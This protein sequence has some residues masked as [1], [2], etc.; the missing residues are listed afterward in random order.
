MGAPIARRLLMAG[1]AVT[2]WN[3]TLSRAGVLTEAGARLA[4]S[5]AESIAGAEIVI[6]MLT[7]DAAVNAALF[8]PG[9]AAPLLR[10]GS[11]VI[12]MST[13]APREVRALA[14]RLPEGIDLVDAPVAGSTGAA[15]AGAL[16]VLAAGQ[17]A[18]LKRVMPVLGALGTVR[19]CGDLGDGSALKLVLNTALATA[20]T[21]LADTLK[22]ASALGVDRDT[23]RE[24][25]AAGPLGGAVRRAAASDASFALALAAKDLDLAVRELG[26]APAPIARVASQVLQAAP[27]QGAD[28]ATLIPQE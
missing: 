7:G 10:P 15:E 27:D 25:L 5:P 17:D 2:V 20:M 13:I 28:I 12:Q 22:V 8:G 6:I 16:L 24:A 26:R 1:H 9:G 23:A 19:R 18:P 4:A 3:R 14:G 21:A 11:C